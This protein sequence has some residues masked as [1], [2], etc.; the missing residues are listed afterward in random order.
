MFGISKENKNESE[1]SQKSKDDKDIITDIQDNKGKSVM[2]P[3]DRTVKVISKSLIDSK[4]I[5]IYKKIKGLNNKFREVFNIYSFTPNLAEGQGECLMPERDAILF[6]KDQV[7][8]VGLVDDIKVVTEDGEFEYD[9]KE[10]KNLYKVEIESLENS[11]QR[12]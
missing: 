4:I 8:V 3:S 2:A 6:W 11:E 1:N 10:S 12:A 7:E 5:V 9:Y